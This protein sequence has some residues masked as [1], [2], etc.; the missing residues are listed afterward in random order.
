[1]A[2]DEIDDGPGRGYRPGGG[3]VPIPDPTKLTLDM[4][5]LAKRELEKLFNSKIDHLDTDIERLESLL[6]ELPRLENAKQEQFK[7]LLDQKFSGV[8]TEFT[9][10]DIALAAAFKAAEAAVAQQNLSNTIAIDKAAVAFTK[11]IDNIDAKINDLKERLG[12]VT[13]FESQ[14][15]GRTQGQVSIGN[16]LYVMAGILAGVAAIIT[17]LILFLRK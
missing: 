1:M 3:L 16:L 7:A 4:V 5:A 17:L 15:T 14:I 13:R 9:M 12:D 6:A 8:A 10:R 2:P 11:Q